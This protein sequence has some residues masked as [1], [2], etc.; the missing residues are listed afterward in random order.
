ML[1]VACQRMNGALGFL[2]IL[3]V[4]KQESGAFA[5]SVG[6][7]PLAGLVLG[8][9]LWVQYVLLQ[10]WINPS[11][12]ALGLV[13]AGAL[14]TKGLHLDGL[15]DSADALLSHR[16][17][18]RMLEIMKDSRIGVMGAMALFF[19]LALRW[20]LLA[21]MPSAVM[22]AALLAAPALGRMAMG[23]GMAAF[24]YARETGLASMFTRGLQKSDTVLLLA[25]G[26]FIAV[27]AAGLAGVLLFSLA[28][29]VAVAVFTWC[30]K[31]LGGYTG[32]ILG[33]VNE[34]VEIAC[35]VFVLVTA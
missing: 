35:M 7:F 30:Q 34:L 2:S 33:A 3:P 20:Q 15:S 18:E 9:L 24:T 16:S 26:A 19:D 32:D 14:W 27:L 5:R 28:I 31:R 10:A 23:L 29:L 4:G 13:L 8:G 21:A 17:P 22:P 1:R 6:F 12:N 25:S 11:L